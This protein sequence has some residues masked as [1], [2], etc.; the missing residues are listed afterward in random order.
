[1]W[2]SVSD[3]VEEFEIPVEPE[4]RVHAP[5][6]KDLCASDVGELLYF[7]VEFIVFECV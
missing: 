7:L 2:E 4:R 5:L 6:H 1:M 3:A